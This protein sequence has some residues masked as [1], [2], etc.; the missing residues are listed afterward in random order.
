MATID[1][2][3]DDASALAKDGEGEGKKEQR[4]EGTRGELTWV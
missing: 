3:I 4:L 1:H 2:Q